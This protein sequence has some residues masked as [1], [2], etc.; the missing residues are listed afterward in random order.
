LSN[1]TTNSDGYKLTAAEERL[2]KVLIDPEHFG[3]SVTDKCQ[4]AGISRE[5]YYNTM[6]K[7][8]FCD[9]YNETVR[10]GLKSSVSEIIKATYNFG[11]RFPGNHQ[12]RKILLE[13]AGAYT[14]KSEVK[15][16][17]IINIALDDDEM[18][19]SQEAEGLEE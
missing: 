10:A 13:M 11:K 17:V 4:A 12:D 15:H 5:T 9:L 2:I 6:K 7:Q 3:K 8:E 16:E 18:P 19:E 14:E 1:I